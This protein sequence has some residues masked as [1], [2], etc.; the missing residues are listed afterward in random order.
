MSRTE[1]L[2]GYNREN[3][4]ER[5]ETS[6]P[7]FFD[8]KETLLRSLPLLFTLSGVLLSAPLLAQTP[9]AKPAPT[10]SVY[11]TG[12]AAGVTYRW[13]DQDLTATLDS[14]GKVAYSV[15]QALKKEFGKPDPENGYSYYEVTFLP[16]SAVGSLFSY[17]RDDYWDGGAHP[18]GGESFV[19]VD[20]RHPTRYL[21]LNDLFDAAQIRQA[22]LS[23]PI[24]QHVLTREKIAPP[25]SLEGLVKALEGKEF[26][27]EGDSMYSFPGGML[28]DFAFHHIENG[29]VAVRILLPPRLGD[30]PLPSH[31]VGTIA[32]D[33]GRAESGSA[34]SRKRAGRRSHAVLT[35][36][37]TEQK[38][39]GSSGRARCPQVGSALACVWI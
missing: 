33:T 26:G 11:W 6:F 31:P 36:Y 15:V 30:L 32:P 38:N 29:K 19:T 14:S 22:L 18:S 37:H 28:S 5:G 2:S 20:A 4:S 1:R 27:G 16:L 13:T 17:E 35:A 10:G 3:L 21:K 7:R 39:F 34:S 24:V 25:P 8:P 23:D 9:G 12:K